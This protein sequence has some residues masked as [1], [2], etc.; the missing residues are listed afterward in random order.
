MYMKQGVDSHNWSDDVGLLPFLFVFSYHIQ[1]EHF[2]NK[3][4]YWLKD[5]F[6]KI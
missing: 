6:K 2:Y 5:R 4:K 3:V 1:T